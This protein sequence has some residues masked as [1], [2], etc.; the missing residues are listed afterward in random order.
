[1]AEAVAKDPGYALAQSMHALLIAENVI[2]GLSE[3]SDAELAEAHKAATLALRLAPRDPAVL[4]TSG[5]ALAYCVDYRK[6]LESLR[7]AVKAAP[8]DLGAW[9]YMG[10]PLAATGSK[11]DIEELLKITERL[12]LSAPS[13]PGVPYW[14]YHRSV[15]LAS[16]G[17]Y[18]GAIDAIEACLAEQ[19]EFAIG[20]MHYANVLGEAGRIEDAISAVSKALQANSALTVQRYAEI[21]GQLTDQKNVREQRLAGLRKAELLVTDN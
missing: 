1:M 5:C 10:W 19:P 6:A 9:G 20:L 15:A 16:T 2:N 21:I 17:D 4:G 13:H 14:Q 3:H 7:H 18:A 8:F 11:A 12:I